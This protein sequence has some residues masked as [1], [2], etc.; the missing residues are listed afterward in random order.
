ML[1]LLQ[2]DNMWEFNKKFAE[3]FKRAGLVQLEVAFDLR[4]DPALLSKVINGKMRAPTWFPDRFKDYEP[5]GV[6]PGDLMEWWNVDE[7]EDITKTKSPEVIAAAAENLPLEE[8]LKL[9]GSVGPE[10]I[11]A[12][13]AADEEEREKI[14]KFIEDVNR[15]TRE[16]SKDVGK[17]KKTKEKS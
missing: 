4:I 14:L 7:I 2:D 5:L 13:E 10:V 11:K 8:R 16:I 3:A 1:K 12:Y 17:V 9:L 6:P 15:W